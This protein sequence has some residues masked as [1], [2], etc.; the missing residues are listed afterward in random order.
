MKDVPKIVLERLRGNAKPGEHPDA[1]LLSAFAEQALGKKERLR[2]LKHLAQCRECREIV[3][4]AQPEAAETQDLF[5]LVTPF[6][7]RSPILRWGALAVCVAVVATV[8]T[9]QQKP[10]ASLTAK[11]PVS[12]TYEAQKTA[13]R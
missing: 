12:A 11:A 13:Q 2:V 7:L 3:F 4:V 5:R 10:E 8:T 1:D 9:R 6:S